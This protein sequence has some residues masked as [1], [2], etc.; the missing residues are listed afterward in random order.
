[1]TWNSIPLKEAMTRLSGPGV[2]LRMFYPASVKPRKPKPA[3]Q[4]AFPAEK[5]AFQIIPSF[6]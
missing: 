6:A 3:P 2:S 1:M 5:F 4:N